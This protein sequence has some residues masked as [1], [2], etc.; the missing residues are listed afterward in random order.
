[1]GEFAGTAVQMGYSCDGVNTRKDPAWTYPKPMAT[2]YIPRKQCI[3]NTLTSDNIG[4]FMQIIA[5]VDELWYCILYDTLSFFVLAKNMHY[6]LY[7]HCCL[8]RFGWQLF[9]R[10]AYPAYQSS[11]KKL[12]TS[13][14]G[15]PKF[16]QIVQAGI[17]GAC[18]ATIK[19]YPLVHDSREL[20]ILALNK[21]ASVDCNVVIYLTE[22]YGKATIQRLT[23]SLT[24]PSDAAAQVT[25]YFVYLSPEQEFECCGVWSECLLPQYLH[26]CVCP[27]CAL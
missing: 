17:D 3:C 13:K 26:I 20:R 24:G 11:E 6:L 7:L 9:L 23:S 12:T 18:N 1:M 15:A 8:Y 10:A 27:A 4:A 19:M 25:T 16:A 14:G 2:W 21:A 5:Y 22:S